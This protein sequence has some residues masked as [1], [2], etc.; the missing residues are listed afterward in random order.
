[1]TDGFRNRVSTN[2]VAQPQRDP[3]AFRSGVAE[4]VQALGEAARRQAAQGQQV[5]E[6]VADSEVRIAKVERDRARSAAIADRMGAWPDVQVSIQSKLDDLRKSAA[7]TDPGYQAKAEAIVN[8]GLTGFTGSLGDDPEVVQRFAPIVATF[9]ASTKQAERRY[10]LT[11]SAKAQGVGIEKWRDAEGVSLFDD[12]TP[13]RLQGVIGST[14]RLIDG[15][16]LPPQVRETYKA[17]AKAGFARNFLDGLLAKDNWQGARGVLTSGLLDGYLDVDAKKLFLR[18]VDNGEQVSRAAV[19]AAE[20]RRLSDARDAAKVVDAKVDAGVDPTPTEMRAARGA[21]VAAGA[22][23]AELVTFDA[24]R[25]KATVNRTYAGASVTT[26]RRDRDALAGKKAAGNASVAEQMMLAQLGRLTEHA[27]E[28]EAT[29]LREMTSRGPAGKLQALSMLAAR[30][31]EERF[32]I[33]EKVQPGMGALTGLGP[34]AQ[35][36]AVQGAEVRAARKAD[37]GKAIDVDRAVKA[38]IGPVISQLGGGYDSVRDVAWDIMAQSV[39]AR[40]GEGIDPKALQAAANTM[41]GAT[42]RRD[43]TMQGGVQRVRGKQVWLPKW[44]TATDFDTQLTTT[45]FGGAVY[46]NGAAADKEDVLAH[47]RPEYFD[48]DGDGRPLYR[49]LDASGRA[50]QAKGGGTFI[51]RPKA[52]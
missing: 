33:A 5:D 42:L 23:E 14:D 17:Q 49:M 24:L 44:A 9:S 51:L 18:Q 8:D 27:E 26:L 25:T 7:P 11:E 39:A 40:G 41:M 29:T 45:D 32:M 3:A 52:Q 21:L 36:A 6:A 30:D 46:A 10:S 43:G 34:K 50:L 1:M 28:K 20:A 48:D 19:E 37:F 47:Y 13:A 16:D 22:D 2:V 15:M 31:P 4:G 38:V 35:L 12:P